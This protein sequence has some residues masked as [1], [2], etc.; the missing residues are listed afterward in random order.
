[1]HNYHPSLEGTPSP[2]SD[3]FHSMALHNG[4]IIYV[5]T[6]KTTQLPKHWC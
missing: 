4:D 1:M 5:E 2:S 3:S 6:S